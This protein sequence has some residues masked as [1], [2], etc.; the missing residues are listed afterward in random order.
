MAL[1][2]ES[3]AVFHDATRARD[4]PVRIYTPDE[5]G[6]HP[7]VLFSHGIGEDRDSYAYIGR[8]LAQNGFV[9]VHITH[10]GMDKA[11]L[12]TGYWKLYKATKVP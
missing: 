8:A 5:A 1:A 3:T 10:A 12:R 7:V 2:G 6:R 11:V 4:I 9:A